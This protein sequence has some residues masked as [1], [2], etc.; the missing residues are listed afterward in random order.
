MVSTFDIRHYNLQQKPGQ[1]IF[2]CYIVLMFALEHQ[3]C[4]MSDLNCNKQESAAQTRQ[5]KEETAGVQ[6]AFDAAKV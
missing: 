1:C 2:M 4:C 6:Q 3:S 5:V